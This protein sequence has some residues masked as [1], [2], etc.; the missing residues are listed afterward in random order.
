VWT[1]NAGLMPIKDVPLGDAKWLVHGSIAYADTREGRDASWKAMH[2]E[3][4]ND[5]DVRHESTAT[6]PAEPS[7]HDPRH[8]A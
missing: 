7:E 2:E 5:P 4:M 1:L 3:V 6:I 8:Q